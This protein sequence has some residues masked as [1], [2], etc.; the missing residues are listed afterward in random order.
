MIPL[1]SGW[2]IYLSE[3]SDLRWRGANVERSSSKIRVIFTHFQ[4]KTYKI[5]KVV[6]NV[7]VFTRFSANLM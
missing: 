6:E 4:L 3:A 1:K 7:Y 5:P 2:E